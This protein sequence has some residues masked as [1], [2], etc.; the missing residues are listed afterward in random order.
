MQSLTHSQTLFAL[1]CYCLCIIIALPVFEFLHEKLEHESLQYVWDKI[2]MPILRAML[3]MLFVYLAYPLNF[4]IQFAPTWS[5]LLTIDNERL[6]LLFNI[7]F[8]VTFIY[9]ILPIIGKADALMIPL[10][11]IIASMIIF[12]WLAEYKTLQ[13]YSLLPD[14][15]TF[16]LI[17]MF[18]SITFFLAKYFAKHLGVWLD[19]TF[20]REGYRIL[21]FQAI[22]MIMQTPIIY[23]YGHA[24]GKQL[25]P[26]F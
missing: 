16:I 4:G 1:M 7:L 5:D 26:T 13:D 15:L 24:L 12:Y 22:I 23:L 8:L 6:N 10:Q 18:G 14:I 20:H 25:M 2:G 11:G 3:L 19:K 21:V 9:P 17:V